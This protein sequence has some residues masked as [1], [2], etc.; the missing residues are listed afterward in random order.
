MAKRKKAFEPVDPTLD[1]NEKVRHLYMLYFAP[2][3]IAT[4]CGVPQVEITILIAD[5]NLKDERH[6]LGSEYLSKCVASHLSGYEEIIGL[7]IENLKRFLLDHSKN[8]HRMS[9]KDAKMM[10]DLVRNIHAMSQLEKQLPTSISK[11]TGA[12]V[13]DMNTALKEALEDLRA[14]DP[15]V[16]YDKPASDD[17]DS[18][19][20]N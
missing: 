12:T 16:S 20:I 4:I 19:N 2:A 3:E 7:S 1:L 11:V 9:V 8:E 10:A 15:F 6:R 14:V 5:L 18:S 13:K 17:D